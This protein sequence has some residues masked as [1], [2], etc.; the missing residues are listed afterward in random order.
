MNVPEE[1]TVY[2]IIVHSSVCKHNV[3]QRKMNPK[4]YELS[5]HHV[6]VFASFKTESQG[7]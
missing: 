3:G 7:I 2:T 1:L 6:I 5:L 4:S